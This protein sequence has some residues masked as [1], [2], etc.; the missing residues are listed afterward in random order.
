[1]AAIKQTEQSSEVSSEV[2]EMD[3][4]DDYVNVKID[5]NESEINNQNLNLKI[6]KLK[7]ENDDLLKTNKKINNKD[8]DEKALQKSND[9]IKKLREENN[10]DGI[11]LIYEGFFVFAGMW[12]YGAGLDEDKIQFSNQWK[13]MSGKQFKYEGDL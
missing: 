2:L 7:I 3:K 1:M 4:V 5:S 8:V 12:A 13:S 10:E 6:N 11:K 9:E